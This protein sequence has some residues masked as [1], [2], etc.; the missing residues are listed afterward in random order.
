MLRRAMRTLQ[1]VLE[2]CSD[3]FYFVYDSVHAAASS[4]DTALIVCAIRCDAEGMRILLE[5]GADVNAR[6]EDGFTALHW[7]AD[8]WK[9]SPEQLLACVRVLLAAGATSQRDY[10]FQWTPR[11]RAVRAGHDDIARLLAEHGH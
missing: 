6:V 2:E 11:E 9:K 7:A 5:H 4:G 8:G 3:E 10:L 1:D